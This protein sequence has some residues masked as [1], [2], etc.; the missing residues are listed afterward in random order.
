ML[1]QLQVCNLKADHRWR[2]Y[3]VG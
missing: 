2:L 3:T 1:P